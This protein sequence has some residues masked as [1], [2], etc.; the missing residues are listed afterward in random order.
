[1]TLWIEAFLVLLMITSLWL[2]GSS[3]LLSCIAA[4]SVQ[5]VLLGRASR[6]SWESMPR[7]G[8]S[9]CRPVSASG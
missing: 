3:R 6:S 4:V 8:A 9:S 7:R 1:M 5:G 2:L